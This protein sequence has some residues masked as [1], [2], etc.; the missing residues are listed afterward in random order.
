MGI[1]NPDD[2]DEEVRPFPLPDSIPSHVLRL[3]RGSLANA[4]L[5]LL[6]PVIG[7]GRA[8]PL[9]RRL[10]DVASEGL[11]DEQLASILQAVFRGHQDALNGMETAVS[12][13]VKPRI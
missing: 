10:F 6:S 4:I 9:E 11:L 5:T 7:A 13:L 1:K 8:T 12:E 2:S 3:G